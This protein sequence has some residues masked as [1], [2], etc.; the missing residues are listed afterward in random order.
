MLTAL[1]LAG[2]ALLWAVIM[3]LQ[4][5]EHKRYVRVCLRSAPRQWHAP[6]HVLVCVPCKGLDLDLASNLR[7]VLSQDY[8]I[9]RVR[10][11]VESVA[12]PAYAVIQRLIATSSVPCELLVAGTCTDS[13][14]KVHNLC[15]ATA[16]LPDDVQVL[17]FFDSDAKPAPDALPRLVNRVCCG[18]LQVATGYRWFVPLRPSV[19]NL[20][21]ASIN[22]AVA[23]MFNHQG[24]NL[25]W[26][27]SWAV[28]RELF[29][30]TALASAWRGTLSDDLVASR[31]MRAA[32]AKVAFEP[33]CMAAS[34]I[35]VNWR[36]AASF[37]RRQ[38]LIGRCYAPRLWWTS[39]L[40]IVLQ[41]A[42][43]LGSI[44]LTPY[45][46]W[47]H[48]TFWYSPLLVSAAL[49]ALAALRGHWRQAAWT[50]RVIAAP[51]ALRVAARFDRWAA[52]WSCLFATG[53]MLAA[54]IGRS[55]TW[56]G[57][58]YHIGPAGRITLLGRVLSADQRHGMIAEQARQV[59]REEAAHRAASDAVKMATTQSSAG[60]PRDNEPPTSSALPKRAA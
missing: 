12:D 11:V 5:H 32:G 30:K 22:A 15:S 33:G 6:P 1:L 48:Y 36:E 3:T 26:G 10:F 41:S 40:L 7:C 58:C 16:E 9:F 17:A 14:Q 54:A 2:V 51:D 49:Y 47:Q 38:F 56:R 55:I 25:V 34:L 59:V 39:I 52:P 42:V 8:P 37:L 35:D 18:E 27:G 60:L 43:L 4:V 24:W 53:V 29:E 13:G 21:L 50:S 45:L 23:S 31:A 28:T 20:T 44:V 57:I 46:A 19:A